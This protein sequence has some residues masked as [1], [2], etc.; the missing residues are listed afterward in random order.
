MTFTRTLKLKRYSP[1]TIRLYSQAL[2]RLDDWLQERGS[3]ARVATADDL[4]AYSE[5]V[6]PFTYGSR[7]TLINAYKAYWRHHLGRTGPSPSESIRCPKKPRMVYKGLDGGEEARLVVK[8]AY[9]IGAEAGLAV[10]LLY[11]AGARCEEAASMPWTADE[12]S[13]LHIMGKGAQ[14]RRVPMHDELRDMLDAHSLLRGDSPFLFPGRYG[15]D[16]H[17]HTQTIRVWV[18]VAGAAAGLGH[19]HPHMLRYTYGGTIV[20]ETKDLRAAAELMGHAPSS[21]GITMGYSRSKV[22][23][24]REAIATL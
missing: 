6:V 4:I 16:T 14:P 22:V 9:A 19:V 15:P 17:V 20:D 18:R 2:R 11:F 7:Q 3:S 12:G 8:H 5:A 10:A 24:L 13:W 21:L 23:R 1:K